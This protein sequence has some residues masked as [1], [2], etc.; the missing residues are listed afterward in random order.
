MVDQ[1]IGKHK[2]IYHKSSDNFCMQGGYKSSGGTVT[3]KKAFKDT[4]YTLVGGIIP[5]TPSTTYE[6]MN[7][8]SQTKTGFTFTQYD[9]YTLKWAAYGYIA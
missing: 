5:G 2:D 1:Y 8:A 6:H 9:G 7:L 3:Y 4:N